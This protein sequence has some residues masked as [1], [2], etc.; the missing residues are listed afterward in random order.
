M[1]ISKNRIKL[2]QGLTCDVTEHLTQNSFEEHFPPNS[3][4]NNLLGNPFD[5]FF[6]VEDLSLSDY[7]RLIDIANDSILQQK[8]PTIYFIYLFRLVFKPP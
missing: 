5:E 8:F 1:D 3:N 2:Y 7:E 4:G 6:E